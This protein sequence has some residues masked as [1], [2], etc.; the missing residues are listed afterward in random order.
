MTEKQRQKYYEQKIEGCLKKYN[1]P[2]TAHKWLIRAE[3]EL[4]D[5]RFCDLVF[6][7]IFE[8]YSV[9]PIFEDAISKAKQTFESTYTSFLKNFQFTQACNFLRLKLQ[10]MGLVFEVEFISRLYKIRDSYL[11]EQQRIKNLS[12]E[13]ED[14][15]TFGKFIEA[16]ELYHQNSDCIEPKDFIP[17]MQS[18]LKKQLIKYLGEGDYVSAK[19]IYQGRSKY[20]SQENY[21]KLIV[22]HTR[23]FL[24]KAFDELNENLSFGKYIAKNNPILEQDSFSKRILGVKDNDEKAIGYFSNRLASKIISDFPVAVAVVPSSTVEKQ[25]NQG[26]RKIAKRLVAS[27]NLIDVTECLSRVQSLEKQKKD[28]TVQDHKGTIRLKS[29]QEI[30]GRKVLLID[31]VKTT[32]KSLDACKELLLDAGADQVKWAV[33]GETACW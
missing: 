25:S 26:I 8:E 7:A 3:E 24:D 22:E 31:D 11:E 12:V 33:L 32:G 30:S 1:D 2:V 18:H 23:V 9:E 15:L 14:L 19:D 21:E 6:S 17:K 13:I 29:P 16:E 28:I 10:E 27:N 20:I 5:S 4:N